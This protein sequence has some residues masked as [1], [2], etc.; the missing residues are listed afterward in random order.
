M[1]REMKNKLIDIL[2][3]L[4]AIVVVMLLFICTVVIAKYAYDNVGHWAGIAFIVAV[5]VSALLIMI[6]SYL[7]TFK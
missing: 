3:V 5:G 4:L 7:F 2:L 6:V 1:K